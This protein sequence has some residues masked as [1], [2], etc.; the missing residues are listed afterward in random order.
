MPLIILK[1]TTLTPIHSG[2]ENSIGPLCRNSGGDATHKTT[3]TISP[4]L[5]PPHKQKNKVYTNCLLLPLYPLQ[6]KFKT[7]I[8]ICFGCQ[9]SYFGFGMVTSPYHGL[10]STH[11]YHNT[12]VILSG[13]SPF[14]RAWSKK[15]SRL[16][17]NKNDLQSSD[18]LWVISNYYQTITFICRR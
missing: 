4:H 7:H 2:R 1:L 6:C 8:F 9:R 11:H 14:L 3:S 12:R 13:R 15:S 10:S 18:C 16:I 17:S 5:H